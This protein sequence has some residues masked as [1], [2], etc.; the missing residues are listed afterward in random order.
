M[1][2]SNLAVVKTIVLDSHQNLREA[3]AALEQQY[4]RF[5]TNGGP[6]SEVDI[7]APQSPDEI[8]GINEDM[9]LQPQKKECLK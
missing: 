9:V 3:H 6:P 2:K 1:T 8:D 5:R 7:L 4:K